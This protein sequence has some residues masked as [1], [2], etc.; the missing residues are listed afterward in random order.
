V[1]EIW[2]QTKTAQQLED[3][4]LFCRQELQISIE[5]T[6][7]SD[8]THNRAV[9]VNLF[10]LLAKGRCYERKTSLVKYVSI[11][12]DRKPDETSKICR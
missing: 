3:L 10:N 2:K 9:A 6:L 7:F 12:F 11:T 5:P 1:T 4:A 8:E